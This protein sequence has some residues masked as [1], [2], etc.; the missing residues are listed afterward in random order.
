MN[1]NADDT[2]PD[3]EADDDILKAAQSGLS[4]A[5]SDK[6]EQYQRT[7]DDLAFSGGEQWS[8]SASAGRA[9]LG[10]PMQV[11]NLIPRL[12]KRVTNPLRS[13]PPSL[14]I[15][16]INAEKDTVEV[17][18]FQGIV[19]SIEARS[20]AKQCVQTVCEHIV[21][22][23]MGWGKIEL[24]Y[25]D[26]S[27][28][29]MDLKISYARDPLSIYLGPH[30]DPSGRD[31]NEAY[32]LSW[33]PKSR[34]F[35]DDES[36]GKDWDFENLRSPSE[37]SVLVMTYWR[38]KTIPATICEWSKKTIADNASY[39]ADYA[40]R[41]QA[42]F[43]N[44]FRLTLSDDDLRDAT[45]A[46]GAPSRSRKTEIRKVEWFK[47]L[48]DRI[49][50]R[51]VFPGSR[52]PLFPAYGNEIRRGDDSFL[53]VG[54]TYD[55]RGSQD[56]VN[57]YASYEQEMMSRQPNP[58]YIGEVRQFLGVEKEWADANVGAAA[59][60][61]YNHVDGVAPPQ[62][63]QIGADLSPIIA[64]RMRSMQDMQE[65]AGLSDLSYQ[66]AVN[67]ESGRAVLLKQKQQDLQTV[68]YTDNVNR[69]YE[70]IGNSLVEIIPLVYTEGRVAELLSE[71][72]KQ[73]FVRLNE[74]TTFRGKPQT[75]DL[76]RWKYRVSV[77]CGP[78]YS[79]L[80]Q[81]AIDTWLSMIQ[82]NPQYVTPLVM[83]VVADSLGS[84][85]SEKVAE[86]ARLSL[87]P[88]MQ[89]DSNG[90]KPLDPQVKSML[91]QMKQALQQASTT[92]EERDEQIKTILGAVAQLQEE[93]QNNVRK[94]AAD[95][96]MNHEDNLAKVEV[97]KIQAGA[98]V[99]VTEREGVNAI[100]EKFST[101]MSDGIANSQAFAALQKITPRV[102]GPMN[103]RG[104]T[105]A[106]T[107]TAQEGSGGLTPGGQNHG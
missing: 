81:E 16:G 86:R 21:Q 76:T 36:A 93:V 71:D 88:E 48:P 17:D 74:Q 7:K 105:A 83:D 56:Q 64:A 62:R 54:L 95:I 22:G 47:C 97:A 90:D 82:A 38:V 18:V 26:E 68:N 55:V 51:G 85:G 92:I 32:E 58:P 67:Q 35:D 70:A 102:A 20:G 4:S 39:S 42:L 103:A 107:L 41:A 25:C 75:I 46:V 77:S 6:S 23:G 31:A 89:A 106:Q 13:S 5:M 28:L 78:S 19:R 59:F 61:R 43:R 84:P 50:S 29:D 57:W 94:I 44:G 11:L 14:K 65:T 15:S 91:D 87:P 45:E 98:K 104:I 52:I 79:S 33:E 3:S 60:L 72:G 2:G 80:K 66:S 63:Q 37:S 40:I 24:D 1:E 101:A 53:F 73:E 10:R 30:S 100:A 99:D 8:D 9:E 27:S 69:M 96:A 49:I 34:Y 12:T